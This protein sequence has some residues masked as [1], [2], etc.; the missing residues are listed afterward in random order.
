ME[1]YGFIVFSAVVCSCVEQ[2]NGLTG[3]LK[4]F[5]LAGDEWGVG[6]CGREEWL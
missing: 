1:I 5:K 2:T 6:G 4:G 3:S